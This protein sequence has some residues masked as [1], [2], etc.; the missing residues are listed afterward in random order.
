VRWEKQGL[1]YAPD[2]RSDWARQ[3][4]FPP[5]PYRLSD[6]VLRIYLAFCDENTVGRLGYVDVDPRDPSRVLGVS[7]R[8]LLDIGQPGAF[9]ENGLLPTSLV[10]YDGK[11]YLYYVGYQLG[12]KVRYFQFQG[13][14]ISEDGGQS[15][16]R[17][18]RTPVID[19]SDAE[20]TNRTSAF[21]MR[22]EGVF[23]MWYV[24]GSDWIMAR[25]KPLP[26]YNLRYLTSEDGRTWGPEG[27]VVLDFA[28]DDEHA[29]GR[30]WILKTD[31]R[32]RMFYSVRSHSKGY[33]LGYAESLDGLTWTRLD[34]QVGIDV[35]ADGWDSEMIQYSSVVSLEGRTVMF[36]NG[37]NC[38]Q[39]GFG[40]AVLT[41]P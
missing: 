2:G 12:H 25:G 10:E 27:R 5:T 28:S 39:T 15:F 21:V 13:L 23:K 41:E 30:P 32:Y 20:L 36:Y 37:N 24:G 31:G 8:P 1:I 18:Q 33:R 17:A 7:E 11:L 40:W 22:D 26:V 35:S 9:D 6:D 4:A 14:A 16:R 38:G 19:R 29:F 3:Y 34:E